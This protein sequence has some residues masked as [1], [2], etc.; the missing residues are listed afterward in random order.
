MA[1]RWWARVV[2]KNKITKEL[3][4]A[5]WIMFTEMQA[6]G[7][8]FRSLHTHVK[9]WACW[10]LGGWVWDKKDSWSLLTSEACRTEEPASARCRSAAEDAW[11]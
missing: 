11:H 10:Q 6:W 5:H 1:W 2:C 7:P 3:K 8:E 4:Q 9:S